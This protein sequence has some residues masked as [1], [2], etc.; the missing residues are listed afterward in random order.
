MC[1]YNGGIPISLAEAFGDID[2]ANVKCDSAATCNELYCLITGTDNDGIYVFDDSKAFWHRESIIPIETGDMVRLAD[3][4]KEVVAYSE[5]ATVESTETG[6]HTS[7]S[8]LATQANNYTDESD[9]SW[10]IQTAEIGYMSPYHKRLNKLLMKLR[11]AYEGKARIEIQY[12]RDGVWHYVNE[13]RPTGRFSSYSV[14]VSPQRCDTFSIKISGKGE[15]SL[16][17]ITKFWAEGSDSE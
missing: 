2:Y 6:I 1:A 5:L 14:P 17:A 16:I 13:L 10:H 3:N 11:L 15:F 7:M 4:S 9:F 12:D 8:Y